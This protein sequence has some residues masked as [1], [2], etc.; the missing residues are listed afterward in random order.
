VGAEPWLPQHWRRNQVIPEASDACPDLAP[1]SGNRV[2]I[3]SISDNSILTLPPGKTDLPHIPL[4][5]MG[6]QGALVWF[7]NRIPLKT[8]RTRGLPLPEP[9]SYDLAVMDG[10]GHY[11]KIS[12]TVISSG[13]WEWSGYRPR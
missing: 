9:G 13:S 4:Q 8:Q 7:L 2:K 6:G 5:A 10:A 3:I 12:F 1:L 11:D